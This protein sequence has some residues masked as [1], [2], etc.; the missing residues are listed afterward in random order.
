MDDTRVYAEE[1]PVAAEQDSV[2]Q[3]AGMPS[4]TVDIPA[5]TV[6]V[7]EQPAANPSAGT[8][9]AEAT[10]PGAAAAA[11]LANDSDDAKQSADQTSTPDSPPHDLMKSARMKYTSELKKAEKA[12]AGHF[13]KEIEAL[14]KATM[15][16]EE[17]VHLVQA[18]K[19]EK[20]AFDSRRLIPW[21]WPMR[22]AVLAY[23]R[24]LTVA[25]TAI[26]KAYD[27]HI[28]SA[29]RAKDDGKVASLREELR[30]AAPRRLLGTW[31]CTGV[32]FKNSWKWELYSD[33][34]LNLGN[35]SPGPGDE[36]LWVLDAK[37]LIVK[38][39]HASDPRVQ[40]VDRCLIS[41]DGTAFTAE[42]NKKDRFAGKLSK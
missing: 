23:L 17:R 12:L 28:A 19:D 36:W 26:R 33:G 14:A 40:T 24:E 6:E 32:T 5:G 15:S 27:H 30:A 10:S 8:E 9:Q 35:R 42:N 13:T 7:E 20:G 4:P 25:E 34:T 2:D 18:L 22:S 21:S 38:A 41:V 31:N 11:D 39:R 29:M 1:S 16:P 37:L 3:T